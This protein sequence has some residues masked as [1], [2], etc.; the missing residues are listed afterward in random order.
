MIAANI[1]SDCNAIPLYDLHRRSHLAR[2]GLLI[3]LGSQRI[4]FALEAAICEQVRQAL[5]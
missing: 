3:I 5:P 2:L 4:P 1:S